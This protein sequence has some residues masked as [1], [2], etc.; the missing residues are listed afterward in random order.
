MARIV[1]LGVL[2]MIFPR[3]PYCVPAVA[4][5]PPRRQPATTGIAERVRAAR[6]S[7]G[8]TWYAVAKRA[9]ILNPS[10]V[11]DMEYGRDTKLSSVEAV[12]KSLGLQLK[13]VE[14]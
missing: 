12:A 9:N 3:T 8:L 14:V 6:Q 4:R 7:Q 5:E 11:R 13:P 10:T 2:A 1:W